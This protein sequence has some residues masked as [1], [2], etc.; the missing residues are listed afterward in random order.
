[1]KQIKTDDEY[2]ITQTS[3]RTWEA[4]S[5]EGNLYYIFADPQTGRMQCSCPFSSIKIR[6]V[7]CKHIKMIKKWFNH[8]G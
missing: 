4:L 5:P 7:P 6:R 8:V 2:I 3:Y 1:M